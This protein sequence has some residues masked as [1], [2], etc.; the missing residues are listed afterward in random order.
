ML[1]KMTAREYDKLPSWTHGKRVDEVT[2]AIAMHAP[3]AMLH[4]QVLLGKVSVSIVDAHGRVAA[5][6]VFCVQRDEWNV[7]GTWC[8]AGRDTATVHLVLAAC[9]STS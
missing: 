7:G 1:T 2:H 6:A 9:R 5:Q 4:V 3:D 8:Y